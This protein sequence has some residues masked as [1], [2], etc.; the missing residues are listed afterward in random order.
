MIQSNLPRS[1]Y[2][3]RVVG[4]GAYVPDQAIDNES[5]TRAIPAWEPS[6]I[7]RLL[8]SPI[9]AAQKGL[10]ARPAVEDGRVRACLVALEARG[11]KLT[12]AA[13]AR[14]LGV[15]P[16]RV[17]GLIAALRRLLNVEGYPVLSVDEA[18]DT[19]ELNRPLLGTQFEL[20]S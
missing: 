11:G 10:A 1:P 16:L 12:R 18:S 9:Y 20:E 17:T 7:E 4:A 19:V 6:W 13:L 8:A 3:V 5:I 2:T 14:A 15:P